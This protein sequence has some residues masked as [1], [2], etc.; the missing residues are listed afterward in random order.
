MNETYVN[1][2]P[3]EWAQEAKEQ[4]I[5]LAEYCRR[6]ARAGRRQFGYDYS[7]PE[8]VPKVKTLKKEEDRPAS[9]IDE[10]LK[11]W[12]FTNLSVDEAQDTDDLLRLL[13]DDIL[14]L[15]DELQEEGRAKYLPSKGGYLKVRDDE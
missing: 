15:A 2:I 11:R 14:R 4:D 3:D 12:I 5:S 6:M 9:Q 8:E 1:G 13:E 10:E 7:H